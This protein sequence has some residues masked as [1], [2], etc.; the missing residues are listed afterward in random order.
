MAVLDEFSQTAE[1]ACIFFF[2]Q[3]LELGVG[4]R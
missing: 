2:Q 4:V 3:Q 1:L